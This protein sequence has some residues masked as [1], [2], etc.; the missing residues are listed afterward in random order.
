MTKIRFSQMKNRSPQKQTVEGQENT[1]VPYKK[2]G[3]N[4][5]LLLVTMRTNAL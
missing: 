4:V 2:N 5:R 1:P 3:F